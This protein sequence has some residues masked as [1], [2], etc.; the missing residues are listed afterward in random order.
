M[1]YYVYGFTY[2]EPFLHLWNEPNMVMVY[3]LL[4]SVRI[5]AYIFFKNIGLEFSF[6]VVSFLDFGMSIMLAS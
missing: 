5:S 2:I 1:L 3:D 4:A 6:L